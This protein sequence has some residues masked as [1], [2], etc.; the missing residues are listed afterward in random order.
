MEQHSEAQKPAGVTAK[1]EKQKDQNLVADVELAAAKDEPMGS[2]A[3]AVPGDDAA[4]ED[5]LAPGRHPGAEEP[6]TGTEA[7]PT[8]GTEFPAVKENPAAVKSA[9]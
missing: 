3:A 8:A 9:T 4:A 5:G 1:D 2:I 7:G 6:N